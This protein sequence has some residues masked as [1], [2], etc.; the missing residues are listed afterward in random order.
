MAPPLSDLYPLDSAD[1]EVLK[2]ADYVRFEIPDLNGVSKGKTMTAPAVASNRLGGISLYAGVLGF[3]ADSTI[4]KL[5]GVADSGHPDCLA[6]PRASEAGISGAL[7]A[8]VW[9]PWKGDRRVAS[10]ICDTKWKHGTDNW[11]AACPRVVARNQLRALADLGWSFKSACE[12]E[13]RVFRADLE[14]KFTPLSSGTHIFGTLAAAEHEEQLFEIEQAMRDGAGIGIET[15]QMEYGS[16][17]F[18]MTLAPQLGLDAADAAFR[19]RQCVK[20]MFQQ[21]GLIATFMTVPI[22]G[23]TANG[24]HF[25]Q[26]LQADGSGNA[27]K[28]ENGQLN[29]TARH[30]LGG[31]LRHAPALTAFHAPTH[32]CYRRLHNPW[33]PS[34]GNWGLEDR[35]E[36]IRLKQ[37]HDGGCYFENRLGCGASNPYLVLAAT[38]AAGMDGLINKIEPPPPGTTE[39]CLELPKSLDSAITALEAD[40]Y[41]ASAMGKGLIRWFQV[42]KAEEFKAIHDPAAKNNPLQQIEKERSMYLRFL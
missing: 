40:T 24:C 33:A 15:L 10:V 42:V 11:Q 17:Q 5:P 18:E 16:S 32:N 21:K 12:Y 13:F 39:G 23:E 20:E 26:S 34:H 28:Y 29:D 1:L 6:V 4:A 22:P 38:V 2:S 30:W 14:G 36:M 25:N 37:E 3:Q 31:L 7:P 27:F 8:A 35:D 41:M 9:L 19:F